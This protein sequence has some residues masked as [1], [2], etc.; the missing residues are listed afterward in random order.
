MTGRDADLEQFLEVLTKLMG[1]HLALGEPL[2][3][4]DRVA[5]LER[6]LA[7]ADVLGLAL[8]TVEM[9]GARRWLADVVR[10]AAHSSPSLALVLAARYTAHRAVR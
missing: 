1:R 7:E 9:D 4:P 2:G 10:T 3:G 8:E 5:A 6:A